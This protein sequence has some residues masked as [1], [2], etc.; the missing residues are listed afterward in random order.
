MGLNIF[1]KVYVVKKLPPPPPP[2]PSPPLNIIL[3]YIKKFKTK[4][5]V[6]IKRYLIKIIKKINNK[7]K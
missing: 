7:F 3:K 6:K 4:K 2:H 5:K 1:W